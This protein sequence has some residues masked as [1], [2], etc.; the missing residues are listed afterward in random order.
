[1]KKGLKEE[2]DVIIN[3][4]IINENNKEEKDKNIQNI[5]DMEIK[6]KN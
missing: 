4:N 5:D 6:L 1:M 2:K 3:N